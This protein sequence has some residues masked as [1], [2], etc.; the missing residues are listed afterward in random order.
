MSEFF[1]DPPEGI[2]LSESRTSTNNAI[3]I[4]LFTLAVIA[5]ILR[6]IARLHFQKVRLEA[7]DYFMYAG[8]VCVYPGYN[9]EIKLNNCAAAGYWKPFLLHCGWFLWAWETHLEP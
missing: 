9:P 2:D 7:D 8:M 1:S 5:V 3:G 4:A 6:T